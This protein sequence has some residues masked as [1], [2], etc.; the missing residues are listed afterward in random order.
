MC[1]YDAAHDLGMVPMTE[2][3]G[4]PHLYAF[5]GWLNAVVAQGTREKVSDRLGPGGSEQVRQDLSGSYLPTWRYVVDTY[6]GPVQA[7][8]GKPLPI[9]DINEGRR[10]HAVAARVAVP[11]T[12]FARAHESFSR[13]AA[14][15]LAGLSLP[16][17]VTLATTNVPGQPYRDIAL[18]CF[19]GSTGLFLASFQ[20][21]IG[22]VYVRLYGDKWGYVRSG[23][24]ILGIGALAAAVT[25]II[26]GVAIHWWIDIALAVLCFGAAT[27][28][29]VRPAIALFDAARFVWI[30]LTAGSRQPR[31]RD[32]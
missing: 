13:V 29:I 22:Y 10:L 21:T 15:V 9:E 4:L 31:A 26:S 3:E 18:A 32:H 7:I 16:A 25:A 12:P 17:I 20:L 11:Y 23:L 14:P 1:E 5:I 8:T 28:V 24:T 19:A 27:Q 6:L 30:S 2:P